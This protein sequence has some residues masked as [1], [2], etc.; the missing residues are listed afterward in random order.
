MGDFN[1]LAESPP[2]P[3]GG[4][5]GGGSP[6]SS[7]LSRLARRPAIREEIEHNEYCWGVIK[8]GASCSASRSACIVCPP[9][10]G[11][12]AAR[13]CCSCGG[14]T[15]RLSR[16]AVGHHRV[17]VSESGIEMQRT[18]GPLD[19]KLCTQ[20]Q[21]VGI[22]H[23]EIGR[24]R[25]T[26]SVASILKPCKFLIEGIMVGLLYAM[27]KNDALS[28]DSIQVAGC[29]ASPG[30]NEKQAAA[31]YAKCAA[32]VQ[33]DVGMVEKDHVQGSSTTIGVIVLVWFVLRASS[34]WLSQVAVLEI[35]SDGCP[36]E[37]SWIYFDGDKRN[38][39]QNALM[40]E[41]YRLRGHEGQSN[42]DQET[43]WTHNSQTLTF[44]RHHIRTSIVTGCCGLG[45]GVEETMAP[46][47]SARWLHLAMAGRT[48][49]AL[50][51]GLIAPAVVLGVL[52][53]G[54]MQVSGLASE[55]SCTEVCSAEPVADPAAAVDG[56]DIAESCTC[57]GYTSNQ[58]LK[59]A[60]TVG[61]II[62]A[63]GGFASWVVSANSFA[64]FGIDFETGSSEASK[65]LAAAGLADNT[66]R[67]A[68][69]KADSE[70]IKATFLHRQLQPAE[71]S[72]TLLKQFRGQTGD[73]MSLSILSIYDDRIELELKTYCHWDCFFCTAPVRN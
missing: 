7:G 27:I 37:D 66:V 20:K 40:D 39:I 60:G 16:T 11:S 36:E 8:W 53:F 33:I 24:Y 49:R 17:R 15:W 32:G 41:Q 54:F 14:L 64:E 70:D 56:V 1:P 45:K 29:E 52:S 67:I 10:V 30:L 22:P 35:F 63:V 42:D 9:F 34:W 50:I 3:G 62:G 51:M 69:P 46:M 13:S 72:Q 19:I 12:G 23:A 25:T 59:W 71:P 47:E 43:T 6:R 58:L 18:R 68:I 48:W 73:T 44:G 57:D 31:E 4:G 26:G 61:A 2:P 5:G 21:N 38:A 55:L 28:P 65:A